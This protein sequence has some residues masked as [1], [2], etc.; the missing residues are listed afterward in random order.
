V[1]ATVVTEVSPLPGATGRDTEQSGRGA[2]PALRCLE[3]SS[4]DRHSAGV[5][6]IL[7]KTDPGQGSTEH[8]FG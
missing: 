3:T 1:P 8:R 4:A 5:S 6:Q 2:T 7:H